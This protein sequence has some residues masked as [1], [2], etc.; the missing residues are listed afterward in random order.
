MFTQCP[1]HQHYHNRKVLD[2]VSTFSQEGK[3]PTFT[4]T[5]AASRGFDDPKASD[6][7]VIEIANDISRHLNAGLVPAIAISEA[8][9][10]RA[11][12]DNFCKGHNLSD[13]LAPGEEAS[14][15]DERWQ[16][17]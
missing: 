7:T 5:R 13:S 17:C 8:Y 14:M 3:A 16:G 2:T 9:T 11:T 12:P 10:D 15:N 6:A 1:I 4:L